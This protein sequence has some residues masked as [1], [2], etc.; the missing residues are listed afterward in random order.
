MKIQSVKYDRYDRSN[1]NNA[2]D[3]LIATLD[4]ALAIE[5]QDRITTSMTF[6]QVWMVLMN[7]LQ[8]T[9]IER[10]EAIKQK[11]KNTL[12]Q[13]YPGQDIGAMAMDVKKHI[14]SLMAANMYEVQLTLDILENFLKAD[15]SEDYLHDLRGLKRPLKDAI[16]DTRYM[17]SQRAGI[18]HLETKQLSHTTIIEFAEN[19]YRSELVRGR[20]GPATNAHDSKDPTA[21][22]GAHH[23]TRKS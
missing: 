1:D 21:M 8:S 9:A 16:A 15:G 3:C 11:L 22:L 20:W 17:D 19:T 10:F 12:P 23:G 6:P 7:I 14:K 13:Q 4:D 5:V 2:K 18:E